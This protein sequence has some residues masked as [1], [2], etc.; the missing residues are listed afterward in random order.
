MGFMKAVAAKLKKAADELKHEL[1][2]SG[3]EDSKIEPVT[4]PEVVLEQ[5][6][7]VVADGVMNDGSIH[8]G[9]K[10]TELIKVLQSQD[11]LL[12]SILSEQR[13]MHS[14]VK[15]RKWESLQ[16]SMTALRQM[17]DTFVELDQ[18]RETIADADRSIYYEPSVEPVFVSLRSKLTKSKIENE[19]LRTYVSTTKDFISNVLD[20]CFVKSATTYSPQGKLV[21]PEVG[22][23]L[24]N[25]DF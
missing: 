11:E 9:D 23:V 7:A 24:V 4:E 1:V 8:S 6:N 25:I 15:D 12:D 22:N 13:K 10:K 20:E 2:S 18:Q 14:D 3:Q 19:A 21:K 16:E 5:E 17:S